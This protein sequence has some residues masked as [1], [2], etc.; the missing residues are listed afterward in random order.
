MALPSIQNPTSARTP[1]DHAR[2]RAIV[3]TLRAN[4]TH[5]VLTMCFTPKIALFSRRDPSPTPPAAPRAANSSDLRRAAPSYSPQHRSVVCN[6]RHS[7]LSFSRSPQCAAPADCKR[8]FAS[9]T[10]PDGR[11]ASASI[12]QVARTGGAP[13]HELEQLADRPAWRHHAH[14]KTTKIFSCRG[15]I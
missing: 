13:H 15:C 11:A 12:D 14:S 10:R 1:P 3:R 4:V 6:C 8:L 2:M 9:W 5:D 7:F